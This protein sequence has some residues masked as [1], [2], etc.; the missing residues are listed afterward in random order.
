MGS[1]T[2]VDNYIKSFPQDRQEVLQT[3][4]KIIHEVIPEVEEAMSYNMPAFKKDGQYVIYF[5][6]WKNHISL[7]PFGADIEKEFPET[8]KYITSGKGTIQFSLDQELPVAL[9]RK[10][11]QFR[12][13]AVQN[14]KIRGVTLSRQSSRRG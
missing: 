2:T 6:G 7:Y 8:K 3:I 14:K 13:Q 12:L 11:T 4:R 5:A 10:I 1:V 9:I